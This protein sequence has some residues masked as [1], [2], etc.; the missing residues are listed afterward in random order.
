MPMRMSKG[1]ISPAAIATFVVA[2]CADS[3]GATTH[4]HDG[5]SS[6]A[7][8]AR[9]P[10]EEMADRD[11]GPASEPYSGLYDDAGTLLPLDSPTPNWDAAVFDN[12]PPAGSAY[13]EVPGS[14]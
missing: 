4:F 13:A 1:R 3:G 7:H 5:G 8:A 10:S 11:A 14:F 6:G 9:E 2:G 12:A